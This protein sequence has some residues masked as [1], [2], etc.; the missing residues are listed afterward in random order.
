[1]VWVYIKHTHTIKHTYT[2]LLQQKN[3][4]SYNLLNKICD[5]IH[6]YIYLHLLLSYM[7]S[8]SE[9]LDRIDQGKTKAI[10]KLLKVQYENRIKLP[11]DFWYLNQHHEIL[12]IISEERK[13][14]FLKTFLI[15]T[16]NGIYNLKKYH[17]EIEFKKFVL[18]FYGFWKIDFEVIT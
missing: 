9:I 17:M 7:F 5:I 11:I 4:L 14:R 3:F 1:M 12:E 16:D 15:R 8:Q 18:E 10:N 2:N 6:V 13:S